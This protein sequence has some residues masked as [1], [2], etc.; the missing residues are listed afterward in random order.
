MNEAKKKISFKQFSRKTKIVSITSL[1]ALILTATLAGAQVATSANG[2]IEAQE[3]P[4]VVANG[5][6]PT[7]PVL[8]MK[9]DGG[10]GYE[11]NKSLIE[12][13]NNASVIAFT[14]DRTSLH[15]KETTNKVKV[16][17]FKPNT[18]CP[19][20]ENI[21][22]LKTSNDGQKIL[23][24][25]TGDLFSCLRGLTEPEHLKVGP[26]MWIIQ[27]NENNDWALEL[28]EESLK[29]CSSINPAINGSGNEIFFAA[30][31]LSEPVFEANQCDIYSKN[32]TNQELTLLSDYSQTGGR[33]TSGDIIASQTG[34]YVAWPTSPS[35]Y[36]S[37]ALSDEVYLSFSDWIYLDRGESKDGS[38]L[39]L[40]PRADPTIRQASKVL[41]F[42][43]SN[44]GVSLIYNSIGKANNGSHV[45]YTYAYK[46]DTHKLYKISDSPFTK[47]TQNAKYAYSKV[48]NVSKLYSL[49][50]ALGEESVIWQSLQLP[51][52]NRSVTILNDRIFYENDQS[53]YDEIF[54]VG[55]TW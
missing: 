31:G 39:S 19:Q 33:T 14:A 9:I 43:E 16:T 35:S 53:N 15:I 55:V 18:D 34:R 22:S 29:M 7:V 42:S 2:V 44:A 38:S 52:F 41:A 37:R 11:N 10:G 20:N 25:T 45:S 17:E 30:R 12:G 6:A 8:F 13:A 32:L 48:N 26:K 5:S 23:V 36:T 46:P 51:V 50:E 21:L 4:L 24:T 49:P 40:I 27:K 28:V 1:S 54:E 3:I 47:V